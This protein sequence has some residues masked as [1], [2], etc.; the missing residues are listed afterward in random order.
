MIAASCKDAA[1]AYASYG[2]SVI[3]IRR[4]EKAPLIRWQEFQQRRAGEKEIGQWFE[5]WP[6]A[7][8]G[9][10]TGT[11]SGIVVLDIDPRHGGD[12]SLTA[13][14]MGQGALP[15]TVEGVTGGGGRH[16]YFSFGD[17]AMRSMVA[18]AKGIDVRAEGG[19]VVAPPS[20]HPSGKLYRWRT[21][22]SP[23]AVA[24]APLPNWL[25]ST[26]LRRTHRQGH[27]LSHWRDLVRDG[28]KE[29]ERNSTIASLSGHL[30]WHGVDPHVVLELLL[31]W[32]RQRCSPPLDD[33][34]VARVVTS[35]TRLHDREDQET[36][37]G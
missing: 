29:G 5:R 26:F 2:W 22:R 6:D 27:D 16:V 32:N 34:E 20:R 30:L 33:D 15:V 18:V 17:I 37:A 13:W 8:I 7:N 31:S 23:D 12:A 3:P 14:Q 24:V 28:V 11:I 1:L 21:G 4:A 19:M 25:K 10:V 36:W 9:V 35:I